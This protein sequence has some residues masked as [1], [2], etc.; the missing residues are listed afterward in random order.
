ME[1]I[2]AAL[3]QLKSSDAKYIGGYANTFVPIAADWT[4]DGE[5]ETDGLIGVR[6]DLD[7][8]LYARHAADW[9]SKGATVIGG[10]YG[11]SPEHIAML[12]TLI[13]ALPPKLLTNWVVVWAGLPNSAL[14]TDFSSESN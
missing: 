1:S 5:A 3:A 8:A 13:K 12:K 4:L 6:H 7:P 9:V 10:C 14:E 2:S 11:T